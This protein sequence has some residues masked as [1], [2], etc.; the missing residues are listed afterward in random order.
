MSPSPATPPPGH[1]CCSRTWEHLSAV[2]SVSS[3][4]YVQVSSCIPN[5]L[6][7]LHAASL[8]VFP[9]LLN[10]PSPLVSL[11]IVAHVPADAF[12]ALSFPRKGAAMNHCFYPRLVSFPGLLKL[13]CSQ[14]AS[15]TWQHEQ[16]DCPLLSVGYPG[17]SEAI[18]VP[19]MG[20]EGAAVTHALLAHQRLKFSRRF[21]DQSSVLTQASFLSQ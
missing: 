1:P 9:G 16:V 14:N 19:Q 18:P 21:G 3:Q 6:F 15:L 17:G 5:A 12:H 8:S 11:D 20:E 2:F 10:V 4:K 7:S 13:F